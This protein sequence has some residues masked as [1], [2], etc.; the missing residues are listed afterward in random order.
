MR[1][2]DPFAAYLEMTEGPCSICGA[3]WACGHR[4]DPERDR[5]RYIRPDGQTLGEYQRERFQRAAYF[6]Y[7]VD[8]AIQVLSENVRVTNQAVQE[9]AATYDALPETTKE[10]VRRLDAFA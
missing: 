4:A 8:E 10:E 2:P 7:A 9:F 6:M 5:L 3:S 1:L